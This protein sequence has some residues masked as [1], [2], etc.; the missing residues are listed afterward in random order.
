MLTGSEERTLLLQ[1]SKKIKQHS[2][3]MSDEFGEERFLERNE[4]DTFGD[5]DKSSSQTIKKSLLGR[6]LRKGSST[7]TD[8]TTISDYE[9]EDEDK[10]DYNSTEEADNDLGSREAQSS[11]RDDEDEQNVSFLRFFFTS[12]GPPQII[13]LSM[14]YALAF[15]STV[16]VVPAV[17]TEKYAVLYH[18]FDGICTDYGRG[19]KPQA[20]LDGSSDAQAAA[21]AASL[22]S[23]AAT[24]L[25]SSLM[26]SLTDEYGRKNFLILAQSLTCLSP[27]ILVLL[28]VFDTMDPSWYYGAHATTGLVNWLAIALSSLSDVMPKQWRAPVFGLLLSAFSVGFS[29]SPIFAI[30]FSHFT[31]SLLSASLTLISLTF[32]IFCLPETLPVQQGMEARIHRVEQYGIQEDESKLRCI[33]RGLLRPFKELSILNRSAIFRLLSALAFFSGMSS[34][35]DQTLL[36][37]YVEDRLDFNDQDVAI[38]FG[39]IGIAGIMVQG[40][41]LK[42][43]TDLIGERL[44]VVFAFTCGAVTNTFYSFANAKSTIFFAIVIASFTGM[45][46]PTISAI[47]SNNAADCEQGR[48]QGALYALSSL[49]S[50]FGPTVLRSA[51]QKTKDTNI[52]GSFFLVATVFYVIAVFVGCLLPKDKANTRRSDRQSYDEIPLSQS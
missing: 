29:L 17:L 4:D 24:F 13:L 22:V 2:Q 26:G 41:L 5:N 51:Y 18:G 27:C 45:S 39:L 16:G 12:R 10:A 14:L 11:Q 47:K 19:D 21:A 42:P 1:G 32:S 31:T 37:Y 15:G 25:T 23:N 36:I 6:F 49:A 30:F 33:I 34:S 28:Q 35:A 48:I 40:V 50:A 9:D 52:P 44:V 38:L 3:L 46:F 7:F 8:R 43:I 20:C